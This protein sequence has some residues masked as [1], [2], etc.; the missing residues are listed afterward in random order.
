[1]PS[2][3]VFTMD[4]RLQTRLE[5]AHGPLSCPRCGAPIRRGQSVV[6]KSRN[7]RRTRASYTVYHEAC[8]EELL[9]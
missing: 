1:M 2:R 4:R 9:H 3:H 8:F 6:S 5:R 7:H